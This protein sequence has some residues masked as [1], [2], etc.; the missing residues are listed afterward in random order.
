VYLSM[1]NFALIA[2]TAYAVLKPSIVGIIPWMSFGVFIGI[3]VGL[4]LVT[5]FLEYK[6]MMPSHIAF[7]NKQVYKHESPVRKDLREVLKRLERIEEKLGI[8]EEVE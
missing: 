4:V 2:P 6:F 8:E 5:M 3:L 7:L 1:I